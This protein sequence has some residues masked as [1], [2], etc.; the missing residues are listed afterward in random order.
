MEKIS[1]DFSRLSDG[2]DRILDLSPMDSGSWPLVFN[3][4]K[5]LEGWVSFEGTLG[6]ITDSKPLTEKEVE[7]L[8]KVLDNSSNKKG[9]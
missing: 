6:M 5:P 3:P 4:S 9:G 2:T 1:P 7:K 8:F